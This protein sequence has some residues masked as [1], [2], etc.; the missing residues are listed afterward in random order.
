MKASAL[1]VPVAFLS[2]PFL[3]VFVGRVQAQTGKLIVI[4]NADSLVARTIEEKQARELIGNVRFTQDRVRVSCDRAVQFLQTG[5]VQLEGDVVIV[6]DSLTM[7]F[8]R[9][10]YFREARVAVAYDSVRLDDG[11]VVLTARY[12]EYHV[13]PRKAFF[14]TRVVAQD[15]ESRLA[16]DSLTYFR[17]EQ[18]TIARSNVEIESFPDRL[19]IRGGEFHSFRK[20]DYSRMTGSPVLVQFDTSTTPFRIDTLV[21]RSK[22]MEA[23]RGDTLKRL[24]ASDGVEIIRSDLA[25][26][27]GIA[28]FYT[29]GDSIHLRQSPVVWYERTQVWGDSINVYLKKRKLDVVHVMGN[30][31]AASQS[32]TLRPDRF[33]QLTGEEMKMYFGENGMERMQVNTRAISLYHLSEDTVA[34]GLNKTSGDRIVME[35]AEK[36]LS[37]IKIFGGVEGTYVPENLLAD[38]ELEYALPGFQWR[39]D[40]P[41]KRPSDFGRADARQ[42]LSTGR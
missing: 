34:N 12:G 32:D 8:P 6:E 42:S 15:K 33:D 25:S 28:R 17:I 41:T 38:K 35:W 29:Q 18:L 21:V 39:T 24:V 27:A 37:T 2:F 14:H 3:M 19:V 4:E 20:E 26:V 10:M 1:V 13:E 11:H 22:V 36:K 30:A 23:F 9:G 16:A 5:N 40:K 31:F 7:T